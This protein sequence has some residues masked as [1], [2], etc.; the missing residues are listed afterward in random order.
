MCGPLPNLLIDP[1]WSDPTLDDLADLL[2]MARCPLLGPDQPAIPLAFTKGGRAVTVQWECGRL[3][4]KPITPDLF[5]LDIVQHICRPVKL[6]RG[7]L[8]RATSAGAV[9]RRINGVPVAED[10]VHYGTP[11]GFPL[12]FARAFLASRRVEWLPKLIGLSAPWWPAARLSVEWNLFADRIVEVPVSTE[13]AAPV[14]T[15]VAVPVST[16]VAVPVLTEVATPEMP[17]PTAQP[18]QPADAPQLA[19]LPLPG[20]PS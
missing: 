10:A 4:A 13:V 6:T 14:S 15:E 20:M 1:A 3:V 9:I 5:A 19:L 2:T 12:S 11:C 16:E 18:A 8:S 17:V 7:W